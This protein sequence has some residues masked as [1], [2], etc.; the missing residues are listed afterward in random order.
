MKL[1]IAIPALNEEESIDS[2][3]RRSIDAREFI[4]ANSPVTEVAITVIS[5]G[6]TDRTVERA[7]QYKHSINLIVFP[8]NK[9]YGAAIKEAWRQ[10]DAELLGFLDAD[11]TC[12]PKFFATLCNTAVAENADVVLGCRLNANSQMPLIR[13]VG[14]FIFA[15]ILSVF[16][17]SR[18]RDT[19]S[20]MRVVRRSSLDR[21]YPL[22]DGLHFT[23]AMSARAML[24]ERTRILEVDMPYH[25]RSGESKLRV[26]KDGLRFLRVI[27]EAAFLYRPSRPL[28]LLAVVFLVFAALLMWSPI[29]YYFRNRAVAE[30]MIYRFLVSDLSG[31]AAC[32]CLC[33]S[34]LTGRMSSIALTEESGDLRSRLSLWLFQ[35]RWFWTV[36]IGFCLVGASLVLASLLHRLTT[37]MTYEH[38]SRYVVMSFCFAV[39]IILSITRVIDYVLNLVG[40]RLEYLKDQRFGTPFV[41][42][43]NHISVP[44]DLET[45][46]NAG[47]IV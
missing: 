41:E 27:I 39:A 12:E 9:G 36:P 17:S 22:P 6:S 43:Q 35:T 29:L 2:I 4:L 38:W 15:T 45:D 13:R 32:L 1:L 26:A 47:T 40:S 20:G 31:I 23:P 19:A 44:T 25:E 18:V 33:A 3:I 5:D 11:G 34:Y 10:S 14:N 37:G 46:K 21:L 28:G 42:P 30:W 24:S 7:S 8:Q 16:S